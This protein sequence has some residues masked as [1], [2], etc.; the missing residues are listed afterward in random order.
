MKINK[1]I[2]YQDKVLKLLSGKMEG[3][4]LA[5]GT[6]LSR[7]YFNHRLSLDLDFFTQNFNPDAIRK[8]VANLEEALGKEIKLAGQTAGKGRVRM[9]VYYLAIDK[10]NTLKMDFVEDWVKL[11][12]PLKSVDGI[13]VLSKEDIYFRKILA[14]AGFIESLD[15]VGRKRFLGGREEAKDFYD[16][17]FLSHTFM[18]LSTFARTYCDASQREGLIRWFRTYGRLDMKTGIMEL[19]A[20]TRP[21]YNQMERHFKKEIDRLIEK[22]IEF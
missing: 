10:E 6:A 13:D 15:V 1:I 7:V 9:V 19:R 22:E 20:Q 2:Q 8:I 14:I 11:I 21:N 18:S 17:Y 5:G 3:F 4:Y 12:K 16:L